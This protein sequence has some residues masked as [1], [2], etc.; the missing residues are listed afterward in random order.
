[1][2]SNIL[3]VDDDPIAIQLLGHILSDLGTLRFATSG[4]D[5]VRLARE[6]SPDLM[7]LDL[8]MP[9]M[10]GLRVCAAFKA[11]PT[12]ADVP[13]VIV[14]SHGG[15]ELEAIL[16]E[17]GAA[18]FIA[19]PFDAPLIRARVETHLRGKHMNDE[20]RSIDLIDVQTGAASRRRFDESLEQEWSRA[21]RAGTALALL[22]I[23]VD[24]FQSFDERYGGPGGEACLQS[25]AR[26]LKGVSR[27]PADLVARYGSDAFVVLLPQT[28]RGGAEHVAHEVLAAVAA[29]GSGQDASSMVRSVTASVGVGCYA[30]A[31]D[32]CIPPESD[33]RHDAQPQALRSAID[34]VRAAESAL[35]SA[36]SAGGNQARLLD[37]VDVAASPAH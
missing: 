29:L 19:K 28:P 26:A 21:R 1:M 25:V 16:L 37:V 6:S 31:S 22:M 34:L 24:H 11:D 36:K 13:V 3:V 35:S 23:D 17:M 12:L 27:R 32:R 20:R 8:K 15:A 30:E 9:G 18:D 4:E 14:T 33:S 7:L 2:N 5:A 10:S